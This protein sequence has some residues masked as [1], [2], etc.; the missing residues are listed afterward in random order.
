MLR[1]C[2]LQAWGEQ[3]IAIVEGH[4]AAT[5]ID[6]LKDGRPEKSR[7]TGPERLRTEEL[8]PKSWK[9]ERRICARIEATELDAVGRIRRG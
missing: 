5:S 2:A 8:R 9:V 4:A 6:G 3:I 1:V 7:R